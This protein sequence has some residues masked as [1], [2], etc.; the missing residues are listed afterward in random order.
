MIKRREMMTMSGGVL[1]AA[2]FPAIAERHSAA[3]DET[4]PVA[5]PNIG[6]APTVQ[7]TDDVSSDRGA[8]I[9]AVGRASQLT[10]IA[11]PAGVDMIV[12]SGFSQKG[13][14]HA[15]YKLLDP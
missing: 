3:R 2:A 11:A 14:G 10:T 7:G 13:L 1:A 5:G 6:R 9:L 4:L 8:S 12:T 15:W